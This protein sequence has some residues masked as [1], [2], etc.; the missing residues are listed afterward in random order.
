MLIRILCQASAQA[1]LPRVQ[2]LNESLTTVACHFTLYGDCIGFS[3]QSS[4]KEITFTLIQ[5]L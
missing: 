3:T 5:E 2:E 1:E 4:S